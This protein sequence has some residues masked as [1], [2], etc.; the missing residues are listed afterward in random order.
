ME[1]KDSIS[2]KRKG[3]IRLFLYWLMF[4]LI[5]FVQTAIAMSDLKDRPSGDLTFHFYQ[6]VLIGS[7]SISV[8]Y[9]LLLLLVLRIRPFVLQ[10][11]IHSLVVM[12][13]WFYENLLVFGDREAGWS[14]YSLGASAYHTWDYS[15]WSISLALAVFFLVLKVMYNKFERDK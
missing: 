10:L 4:V 8:F 14:T 3:R 15:L 11:V 12:G 5:S 7:L 13:L 9:M 2:R 6:D 1:T